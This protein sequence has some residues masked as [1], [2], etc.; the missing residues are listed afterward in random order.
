[1]TGTSHLRP[2]FWFPGIPGNAPGNLYD[3]P[4]IPGDF[5]EY[6]THMQAVFGLSDISIML[7]DVS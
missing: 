4:G 5:S 2:D 6:F 7:A 1:M 3:L